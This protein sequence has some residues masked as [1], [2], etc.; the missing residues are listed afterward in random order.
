MLCIDLYCLFLLDLFWCCKCFNFLQILIS[1]LEHMTTAATAQWLGAWEMHGSNCHIS[2]RC[3]CGSANEHVHFPHSGKKSN[4]IRWWV[5]RLPFLLLCCCFSCGWWCFLACLML[6][7]ALNGLF[8]LICSD[9]VSTLI[10]YR[11]QISNLNLSQDYF[12]TETITNN[13]ICSTE[14]MQVY[15]LTC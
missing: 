10:F 2:G 3:M 15:F 12:G 8:W 9:F 5:I 7:I 1:K 13:N 14:V 11:I 6:C 4:C